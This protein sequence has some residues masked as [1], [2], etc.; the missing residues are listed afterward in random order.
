MVKLSKLRITAS[1]RRA[2]ERPFYALLNAEYIK[3]AARKYTTYIMKCRRRVTFIV[4]KSFR[5]AARN[6][7]LLQLEA[8]PCLETGACVR[9][10]APEVPLSPKVE[11]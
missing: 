7:L 6:S 1:A 2:N 3:R 8:V 10:C 5:R 11:S 9:A 4:S